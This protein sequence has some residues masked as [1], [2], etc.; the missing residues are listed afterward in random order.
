MNKQSPHKAGSAG[1]HRGDLPSM[2]VGEDDRHLR[3]HVR[4]RAHAILAE[5][6]PHT[7]IYW[8]TIIVLATRIAEDIE[9]AL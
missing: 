1:S 6:D 9:A 5:T 3:W 7:G 2:R 8:D 4:A